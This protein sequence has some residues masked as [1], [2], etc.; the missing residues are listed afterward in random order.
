MCSGSDGVRWGKSKLARRTCEQRKVIWTRC[1]SRVLDLTV[2]KR[3][4]SW[5]PETEFCAMLDF[6]R[7]W[8]KF[9]RLMSFYAEWG[10]LMSTF[11]NYLPVPSSRVMLLSRTSWSFW[12]R[13]ICGPETPVWSHLM[14][15]KNPK[16]KRIRL[17]ATTETRHQDHQTAW[18]WL[19][20]VETE[21]RTSWKGAC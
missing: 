19:V 20:F 3:V 8:N 10:G 1:R 4:A 12:I 7:R 13:P 6:R 21:K 14:Q 18:I 11:R 5:P 16:G 17:W 9:F 2:D 15:R